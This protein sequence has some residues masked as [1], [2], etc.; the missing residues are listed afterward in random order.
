[1]TPLTSDSLNHSLKRF[2]HLET[3]Q[4]T[5]FMNGSWSHWLKIYC[6]CLEIFSLAKQN[7]NTLLFLKCNSLNINSL[8]LLKCW[9]KISHLRWRSYG[10]IWENSF[11]VRYYLT[12]SY[13]INI[14]TK[15]LYR[16][17]FCFHHRGILMHGNSFI[18]ECFRTL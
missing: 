3:K 13:L 5:D 9:I 6:F 12:I 8:G 18:R 11:L 7:K 15:D 14:K 17:I 1:M 10:D 16:D 4:L 2:M